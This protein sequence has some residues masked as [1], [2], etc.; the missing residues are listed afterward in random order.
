M[1]DPGTYNKKEKTER[2]KK[3]LS[4]I[5]HSRAKRIPQK[6]THGKNPGI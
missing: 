1:V 6:D 4:K 2:L 3:T 5:S